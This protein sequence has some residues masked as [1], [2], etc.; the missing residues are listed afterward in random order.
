[1]KPTEKP[2]YV[3]NRDFSNAVNEYVIKANAAK[4]ADAPIP[5]ITNY[6]GECFLRISEGLSHKHNFARYT[7][8]EE[9]VMDAVENCI[10][11]INNYD[12]EKATRTGKPNAFSYFTQI[13]Y[14]AFLRRIEKEK[15]VQDIKWNYIERAGIEEFVHY[16]DHDIGETHVSEQAFVDMLKDRIDRVKDHDRAIKQVEK[17]NKAKQKKGDSPDLSIFTRL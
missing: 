13:A 3:N 2:H 4:E 1:M 14:F 12:I 15:K 8:R 7:Y 5:Q 9:M 6:I 11:A 16:G 17:R 10:K